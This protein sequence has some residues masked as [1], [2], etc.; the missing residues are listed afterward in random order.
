MQRCVVLG[1][2]LAIV[3]RVAVVNEVRAGL[4]SDKARVDEYVGFRW[5]GASHLPINRGNNRG[6]NTGVDTHRHRLGGRHKHK[7]WEHSTYTGRAQYNTH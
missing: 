1:L 5:F 3:P 4:E 7:A 2:G 6:Y